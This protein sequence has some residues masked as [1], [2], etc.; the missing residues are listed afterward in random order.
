MKTADLSAALSPRLENKERRVTGSCLSCP[1]HCSM[2]Q[3]GRIS[4]PASPRYCPAL[5]TATKLALKIIAQGSRGRVIEKEKKLCFEL[6]FKASCWVNEAEREQKREPQ[7][8]SYS[9]FSH[10]RERWTNWLKIALLNVIACC[11]YLIHLM[12]QPA[13]RSQIPP[14]S[15]PHAD[16]RVPSLLPTETEPRSSKC[17]PRAK[18]RPKIH[19]APA[20]ATSALPSLD[21]PASQQ[22]TSFSINLL[23]RCA[24]YLSSAL[25]NS[26]T[27]FETQFAEK[28]LRKIKLY[29]L[30]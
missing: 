7:C 22:C 16:R 20:Q 25:F 4:H 28:A 3:S 13:L 14:T 6:R 12:A 17:T 24:Y 30:F 27:C 19:M 8:N 23:S 5:N 26:P 2:L 10:E 18:E 11:T 9:V 15:L 1:Q 29:L 21:F